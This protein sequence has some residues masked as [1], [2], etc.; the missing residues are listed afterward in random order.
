MVDHAIT[1]GQTKSRTTVRIRF[2]GALIL[3]VVGGVLLLFALSPGWLYPRDVSVRQLQEHPSVYVGQKVN[4]V[5][6]LVKYTAP[7]FGDSYNLCEGDPRNLYFAVNPCIAVTGASSTIDPYL[8]LAYDGTDYKVV[9]SPCSFAVPCRVMVSGVLIDRGPV[10]DAS[11]YV[12]E[13][14]SATWHE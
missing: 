14:S 13:T 8:S 4:T 10:T 6:Y 11:Q 3:L 5:G 2:L 7:H 1:T 9:P 12:I